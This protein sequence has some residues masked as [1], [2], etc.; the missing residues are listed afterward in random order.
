MSFPWR[1]TVTLSGLYLI[2]KAG[3]DPVAGVSFWKVISQ[4][5]WAGGLRQCGE[6][7]FG[8]DSPS[9]GGGSTGK[10]AF[11]QTP[12]QKIAPMT[13]SERENCVVPP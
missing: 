2:S 7:S 12:K 5:L 9:T 6:E 4:R 13:F 10:A 3:P 1:V 8:V 11:I